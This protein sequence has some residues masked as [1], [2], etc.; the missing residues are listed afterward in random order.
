MAFEKGKSGN[1]GGRPKADTIVVSQARKHAIKAIE[2]LASIVDDAGAPAASRVSAACA[3][4]DRG[5]GKP[6]QESTLNINDKRNATDWTRDEL[7]AFLND[8]RNGSNGAAEAD[9]GDREPD[10]LH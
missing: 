7:V 4:L 8:A 1:P 3:L 2:A 10:S 5:Y 9:G 6:P